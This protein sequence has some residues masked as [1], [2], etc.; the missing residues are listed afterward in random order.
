MQ[1]LLMSD[2]VQLSGIIVPRWDVV[3]PGE[4][5]TVELVLLVNS[6]QVCEV[7][8]RLLSW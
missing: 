6:A 3:K 2:D 7:H 8:F 1:I 4:R 5:C